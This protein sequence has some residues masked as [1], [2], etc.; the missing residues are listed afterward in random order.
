[1]TLVLPKTSKTSEFALFFLQK[2]GIVS[3]SPF[4]SQY[5]GIFFFLWNHLLWLCTISLS[6]VPPFIIRSPPCNTHSYFLP[7]INFLQLLHSIMWLLFYLLL[8]I[9]VLSVFRLIFFFAFSISPDIY[10]A[11]FVGS[12]KARVPLLLHHLNSYNVFLFIYF[13]YLNT[14][15]ILQR[16]EIKEMQAGGVTSRERVPGCWDYEVSWRLVFNQL[17]HPGSVIAFI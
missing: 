17:T 13:Y 4:T 1:M 6:L 12:N 3:P 9:F 8:W 2:F 14:L 5:F 10:L 16:R 15:F 7:Q 11:M